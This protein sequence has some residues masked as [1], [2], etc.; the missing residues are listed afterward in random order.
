MGACVVCGVHFTAYREGNE[1]FCSLTCL[2]KSEMQQFCDSCLSETTSESPGNTITVNLVGTELYGC[3]SR[4]PICHSIVQEK[5]IRVFFPASSGQKYR[6]IH[7]GGG[8][9]I[10]RKIIDQNRYA[11]GSL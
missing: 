9:Y 11:T 1:V 5:G 10:G 4:C 6:V 3:Q 8:R 2:C 7:L